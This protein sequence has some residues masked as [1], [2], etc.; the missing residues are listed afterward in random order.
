MLHKQ[1]LL[2]HTPQVGMFRNQK[3]ESQSGKNRAKTG[4][5]F[6]DKERPI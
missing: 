6:T 1:K 5:V 2:D 3:L 4:N